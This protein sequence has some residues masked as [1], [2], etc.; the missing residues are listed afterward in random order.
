MVLHFR[1]GDYV[2][3]SKFMGLLGS[4]YY[5]QALERIPESLSH[6]PIWVFSDEPEE[7]KRFFSGWRN[8]FRFIVPP[9]T[10]EPGES[11][12]LMSYGHGH[13]ISNS[14]FAWWAATLS[15]TSKFVSVPQPWLKGN[16][17]PEELFQ[18][19]WFVIPHDWD[20][21]ST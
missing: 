4:D 3:V 18:D 19:S 1:R 14:T 16:S 5:R 7:A 11:L 10:S 9:S 17:D 20:L 21:K 12:V 2:K 13:I 8:N 15:P 6:R